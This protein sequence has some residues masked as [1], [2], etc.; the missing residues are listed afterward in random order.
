LGLPRTS[1]V[2]SAESPSFTDEPLLKCSFVTPFGPGYMLRRNA[3]DVS[4]AASSGHVYSNIT[5]P[6]NMFFKLFTVCQKQTP[7]AYSQ[8]S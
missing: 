1:A 2:W 6:M 3:E 8:T 7:S 5:L 4:K